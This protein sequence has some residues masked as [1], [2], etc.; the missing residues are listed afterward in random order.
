[1]T[2]TEIAAISEIV[3]TP[4]P[5]AKVSKKRSELEVAVE[6]ADHAPALAALSGYGAAT[7]TCLAHCGEYGA[8]AFFGAISAIPLI[9][10]EVN[11]CRT[12][13]A[14]SDLPATK[15]L[16]KCADSL[17]RSRAMAA[18]CGAAM[19]AI[20]F[21]DSTPILALWLG[22]VIVAT[23]LSF[24]KESNQATE[25]AKVTKKPRQMGRTFPSPKPL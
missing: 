1:M 25:M 16:L 5:A 15:A 20:Q 17:S 18:L 3:P 9:A 6:T 4:E 7:A 23:G 14:L 10:S 22:P 19:G 11:F 21:T 24:A 12:R 2:T 8:A 13:K